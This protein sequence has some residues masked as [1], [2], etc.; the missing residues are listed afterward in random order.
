MTPSPTP[1]APIARFAVACVT[2][3]LVTGAQASD[4]HHTAV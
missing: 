1:V 4:A 2:A 3:L